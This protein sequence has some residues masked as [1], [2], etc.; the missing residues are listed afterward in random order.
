MK[1]CLGGCQKPFCSNIHDLNELE[2]MSFV[3]WQGQH[4]SFFGD[5]SD[6]GCSR[7]NS[8]DEAEGQLGGKREE[9]LPQQPS[10]CSTVGPLSEQSGG[11]SD[12]GDDT[13]KAEATDAGKLDRATRSACRHCVR[14]GK[15][16]RDRYRRLVARISSQIREDPAA[17]NA[18]ALK[19]L[20]VPVSVASHSV[21]M[22][23]MTARL[24]RLADSLVSG[25]NV[26]QGAEQDPP[27]GACEANAA[28]HYAGNVSPRGSAR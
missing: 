28:F 21:V 5:S 6:S 22:R 15:G 9:L 8:D 10:R 2:I 11:P 16:K 13:L 19:D 23:K 4:H 27:P 14:P 12:S 24:Q 26:E 18:D 25:E 1:Y 7:F 3:S 17:W 20:G